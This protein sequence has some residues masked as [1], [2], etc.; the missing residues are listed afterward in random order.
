M[1]RYYLAE[2]PRGEGAENYTVIKGKDGRDAIG[3]KKTYPLMIRI[4]RQSGLTEAEQIQAKM[5]RRRKGP[6][7]VEE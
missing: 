1:K 2:A 6:M 5:S 4:D 3:P 7:F